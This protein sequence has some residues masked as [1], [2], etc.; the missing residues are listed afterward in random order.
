MEV[1]FLMTFKYFYMFFLMI[2]Y[3][4]NDDVL[5]GAISFIIIFLAVVLDL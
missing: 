1:F 2:N 3:I 4:H 5:D